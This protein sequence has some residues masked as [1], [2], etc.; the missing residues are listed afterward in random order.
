MRA[1]DHLVVIDWEWA[2]LYPAHYDLAFLWYSLVD[3]PGGRAHLETLCAGDTPSF[4]LSALLIQLHHLQWY[5][6]PEF[7][8]THLATRDELISRV[9]RSSKM[10]S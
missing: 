4:L 10:H 1:A 8:S 7:Q 9:L 2:G 6:P 3:V 5:V